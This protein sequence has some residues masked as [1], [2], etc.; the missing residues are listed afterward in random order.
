MRKKYKSRVC[1]KVVRRWGSEDSKMIK[2]IDI[3]IFKVL[4][5]FGNIGD[6]GTDFLMSGRSS[7]S[8]ISL[9][10]SEAIKTKPLGPLSRRNGCGLLESY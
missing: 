3:S 2:F 5:I 8:A 7:K 10:L 1:D 4:I 9:V 6:V